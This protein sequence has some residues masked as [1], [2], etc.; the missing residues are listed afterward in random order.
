MFLIN[1]Y[2]WFIQ[3]ALYLFFYLIVNKRFLIYVYAEQDILTI[4][5]ISL[6]L[7]PVSNWNIVNPELIEKLQLFFFFPG[8]EW[9]KKTWKN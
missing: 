6:L 4:L 9:K 1:F 7:Y 5:F 3:Q 2:P 8:M